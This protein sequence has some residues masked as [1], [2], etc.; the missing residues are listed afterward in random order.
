MAS[1]FTIA[2]I[3][4]IIIL[5]WILFEVKRA[6]HKIFAMFLI[7]LILFSYFSFTFVIKKNDVDIKSSSGMAEAGRLYF[8]WLGSLFGNLRTITANA[9]KM[10]WKGED[11][12]KNTTRVR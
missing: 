6:R 3:A 2:I 5:I 9:I 11:V 8:S 4:G 12:G 1:G 10:D 7:A